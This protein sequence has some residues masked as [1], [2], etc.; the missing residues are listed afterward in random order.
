MTVLIPYLIKELNVWSG[1]FIT[2]EEASSG[3]GY[4]DQPNP[5]DDIQASLWE[6]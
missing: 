3:W 4:L 6:M 1:I 2:T 5:T